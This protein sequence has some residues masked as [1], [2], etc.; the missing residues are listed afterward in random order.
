SADA[1]EAAPERHEYR[2][3]RV[4]G[5]YHEAGAFLLRGRG[6]QGSPG[7]H[8]VTPLQLRD[9]DRAVLVDRGWLPAP[10]ATTVHPRPYQQRGLVRLEGIIHL[11]PP[12]G[13]E[14]GRP[15]LARVDGLAIPT[16]QRLD[17]PALEAASPLSLLP[18]YVE[19]AATG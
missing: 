14:R 13:P 6:R 3:I 4:T 2:R 15:L 5:T 1:I 11:P 8:L 9:V 18:V 12:P 7:V 10:D 19:R 16:Y 17:M